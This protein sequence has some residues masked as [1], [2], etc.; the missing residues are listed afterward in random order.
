MRSITDNSILADKLDMVKTNMMM[1]YNP[2]Y[3]S[4]T[5]LKVQDEGDES[6]GK[7]P[8]FINEG[9]SSLMAGNSTAADMLEENGLDESMLSSLT[10]EQK[11]LIGAYQPKTRFKEKVQSDG[12]TIV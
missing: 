5:A 9:S 11:L 6:Q 2:S 12:I 1:M 7:G 4:T 8:A 10:L 3:P